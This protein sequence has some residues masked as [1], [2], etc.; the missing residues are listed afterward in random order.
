MFY[1]VYEIFH[2]LDMLRFPF[3]VQCKSAIHS[4][5]KEINLYMLFIYMALFMAIIFLADC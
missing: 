1:Y 2:D 5:K 3:C 4:V